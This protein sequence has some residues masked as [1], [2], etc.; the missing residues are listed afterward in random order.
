MLLN[1]VLVYVLVALVCGLLGQA[2]AGRSSSGVIGS[3]VVALTGAV[4]AGNAARFV[5]A[6]EPFPYEAGRRT[7]PVLWTVVGAAVMT[8]IACL[9]GSRETG[10]RDS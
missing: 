2:L 10:S 4:L 6:P 8:A 1:E 5:E 3:T 7:I 9:S